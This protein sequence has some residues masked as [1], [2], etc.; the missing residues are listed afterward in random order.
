MELMQYV[1][2]TNLY[3]FN[4]NYDIENG[5]MLPGLIKKILLA[6]KNGDTQI[7]LWGTGTPRREALYSEDC[8]DAIIYL[9]NNY[10]SD[11]MIN[12]G[13]GFDYSIKEIAEIMKKEIGW[14]GEIKWDLSKPD[15]TFEKR[16]DIQRLKKI[17]PEF[18]PIT[19]KEGVNKIIND[20]EQIERIL[21]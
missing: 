12:I 10:S 2:P 13:T 11:Q 15:G 7:I 17:Y 6:K 21:K 9:M 16:T 5:H 18:N 14:D 8:A 19:L 20:K 1:M 4:D 3:G